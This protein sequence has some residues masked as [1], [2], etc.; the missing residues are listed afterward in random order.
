MADEIPFVRKE[1]SD[2]VA[3]VI[4][5]AL[6]RAGLGRQGKRLWYD[7]RDDTS[8]VLVEIQVS[9]YTTRTRLEFTVNTAVWPPG[10]WEIRQRAHPVYAAEPIPFT[11]SAPVFAR[12]RQ[13]RPDL[14]PEKDSVEVTL[15]DGV[16]RAAADLLVFL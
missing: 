15:G 16:G 4:Y 5:P 2:Q 12:P 11:S 6:K 13:V 8:W 9:D 7:R 1:F 14:W 10:T 3:R